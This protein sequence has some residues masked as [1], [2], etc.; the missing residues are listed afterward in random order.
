MNFP[1]ACFKGSS[2]VPILQGVARLHDSTTSLA[3]PVDYTGLKRRCYSKQTSA[4]GRQSAAPRNRQYFLYYGSWEKHVRTQ[5][6]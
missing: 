5:V 2:K 3:Q 1:F 6:F 4:Q